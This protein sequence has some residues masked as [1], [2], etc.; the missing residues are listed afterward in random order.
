[1][2]IDKVGIDEV[3]DT[4]TIHQNQQKMAVVVRHEAQQCSSTV[5]LAMAEVHPAESALSLLAVL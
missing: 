2:G 3:G 4:A 1:M 5:S